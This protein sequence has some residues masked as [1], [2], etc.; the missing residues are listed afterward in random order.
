[1]LPRRSGPAAPR[2]R[3]LACL[4][5]G[6]LLLGSPASS[7]AADDDHAWLVVD[8]PAPRSAT[9]A[10]SWLEVQGHGGTRRGTG[11]DVVIALDL[12][13]STLEDTGVDLDGDGPEGSSD[14]E[15]LAW[16]ENQLD[17]DELVRRFRRQ[18]FE[19]TVLAAELVAAEALVER[20]DPARFRVGLLVFSDEARVVAPLEAPRETL[21]SA[22][23]SLRRDFHYALGGTNFADAVAGAH[24]LLRPDPDAPVDDGRLRSIVFLSDGAPTRPVRAGRAERYALDAAQAAGRDGVR[25]YAFAIGPEAEAALDVMERMAGW[26]SGRLEQVSRPA[27]IVARLRRLDLADLAEVEVANTTTG[28]DARA[29]RVFPD[30]SFDAFVPLAPGRN[31]LRFEAR[32]RDGS[33]HVVERMVTYRPPA[34]DASATPDVAAGPDELVE[35]L[36]QRTQEMEAWADLERE[37]RRG[38]RQRRELEVAPE[39]RPAAPADEGG[40]GRTP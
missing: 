34:R 39:A 4:L 12:S 36:R 9:V 25:L 33:E 31:R 13:E 2:V 21:S 1:M 26:T 19:D 22:L 6:C 38:P 15:L 32:A 17:D 35:R 16:L 37:R 40:A 27:S 14:P 8:A 3:R 10:S 23:R 7:P 24:G 28:Q 5:A 20:L 18:D 30:G 29:L 11:H